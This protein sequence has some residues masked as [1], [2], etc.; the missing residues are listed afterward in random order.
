MCL[1]RSSVTTI[2]TKINLSKES[3][4]LNKVIRV[5]KEPT[6]TGDTQFSHKCKPLLK[7][8]LKNKQVLLIA[9]RIQI[10]I[11]RVLRGS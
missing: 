2:L 8:S 5:V 7:M 9:L 10:T 4:E 11:L 3:R 6:Q 1:I